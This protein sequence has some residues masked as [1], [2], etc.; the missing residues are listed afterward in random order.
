M[1]TLMLD[2][3]HQVSVFADEFIAGREVHN[4][5]G[6]IDGGNAARRSGHPQVLTDLDS[7]TSAPSVKNH[8]GAKGHFF[9]SHHDRILASDS[10][11][12]ARGE[13]AFLVK[14]LVVGDIGLGNYPHLAMI[15]HHRTVEQVTAATQGG[16]HHNHDGSV[17]VM[18]TQRE[19]RLFGRVQQQLVAEQIGTR[20]AR[21][22]QFRERHDMSARL[23]SLVQTLDD[24][25]QVTLNVS[26]IDLRHNSCHTHQTIIGHNLV[27]YFSHILN[28]FDRRFN[29]Q[30][31]AFSLES[32]HFLSIFTIK[33]CTFHHASLTL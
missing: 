23:D 5:I 33:S 22:T 7:H 10:S 26:H 31:Y 16:S 19:Q 24:M 27:I 25:R 21:D 29:L 1:G 9:T 14:F 28:Y 17:L 18:V 20:V 8:V 11:D 15:D 12:I 30:S 2:K 4:H 3:V 6:T 13:P 32:T